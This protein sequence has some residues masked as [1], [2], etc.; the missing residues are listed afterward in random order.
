MDSGMNKD[1][2]I[3]FSKQKFSPLKAKSEE[4]DIIDIAHALSLMCRANGHIK[5]FY[6]VAQHCLNCLKE[7]EA[8]G[9]REDVRLAC[10]LHDA[11][12]AYLSDITR[13]VKR[14]L[15]QYREFEEVLQNQIYDKF[16]L[17]HLREAEHALVK[18]IDDALLYYELLELMNEEIFE[19]PPAIASMPDLEQRDFPAV[20]K[21]F[22]AEYGRL[23]Q[24]T[25]FAEIQFEK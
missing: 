2:I 1:F 11:S 18:E 21:A 22:L 7:A 23:V 12:E 3:T 14:S 17:V 5:H 4:I 16:N 8:R 10:L 9:L 25:S 20:E 19:A 24:R 13:P 6:S 15:P